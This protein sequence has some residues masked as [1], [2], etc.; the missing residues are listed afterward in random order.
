MKRNKIIIC[1][2]SPLLIL[3]LVWL[4]LDKDLFFLGKNY[5]EYNNILPLNVQP[6]YR[7]SFE[8]G[9]ALNDAGGMPIVSTF[10][11]FVNKNGER[12]T[13]NRIIE[14][15]I[16]NERIIVEVE[17]KNKGVGYVEIAKDTF[18][19]ICEN[20]F[21]IRELTQNAISISQWYVVPS[22]ILPI[23]ELIRNI[24]SVLIFV[25]FVFLLY[26]LFFRLQK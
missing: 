8:G 26:I 3:S 9:F 17:T 5:I 21:Y 24:I 1:V 12:D 16:Q 14:Y 7:H 13:I 23:Q 18:N 20:C 19:N 6:Y 10:A 2:F 22:N 11:T 4:K 15:G 25:G